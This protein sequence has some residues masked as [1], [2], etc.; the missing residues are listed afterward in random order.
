[1]KK[2]DVL[3]LIKLHFEND[4][5]GFINQTN[6][7]AR[8]FEKDGDYQLSEYI[9]G[10]VSKTNVLLPQEFGYNTNFLEKVNLI[11][12]SLYL[13]KKLEQETIGIMNAINGNLKMNKFLFEGAP[14][15]GKTETAKQIA[16]ILERDLFVVEFNYVI[17]SKLGQTSKNIKELFVEIN[18]LPNPRKAIILFD[19]IDAIALDRINSNDLREMGRVTSS[20]IK[21]LDKLSNDIVIIATTNLYKSL[22]KALARR[23]DTIITFD[24][25]EKND[26]IKIA[27]LL[28]DK[29]IS[30]YSNIRKNKKLFYKIL[31][32]SQNIPYPGDLKNIIKT[33]IAFS[34]TSQPY[35]YL[36]RLF[37][38]IVESEKNVELKD[39]REYGF[40]LREIEI[41]TG[42]S[43]SN[44]SKKL[45][46][47]D[48]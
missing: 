39:L 20:I 18:S 19:E 42:V 22:D 41:L 34:D 21:E 10:L 27:E 23:F 44:V 14:G 46:E 45:R 15:T 47:K 13:P 40:T 26:L 2:K 36:R 9:L 17:D 25:Y 32:L 37:K 6:E 16:R 43:K 12:D 11:S 29:Y 5:E 28:L 38:S 31:N 8:S 35:D 1:M 3:N 33:S 24:Q 7:I 4:N 30:K 48:E